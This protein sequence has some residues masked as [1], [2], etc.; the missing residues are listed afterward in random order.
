MVM[1]SVR[2]D[3]PLDLGRLAGAMAEV[4]AVMRTPMD[5]DQTL[6]MIT[7]SAADTVP[8]VIEASISVT[9][10][11]GRIDTLAPT[12][13]L[14]VQGDQLQ[15]D[16]HEGP[17]LDA[18]LGEPVVTVGDL[19]TDPRWPAFGPKAA[20]LGLGGHLAFQ[21][22]A[23][24]H[25]RGALNLYSIEPYGIDEDSVHLGSLFAGQL[26]LAMGWAKQDE[27]MSDALATRNVIGQAVGL[28]M[29]RYTLD[30]DRAFAFL[31]RLSQTSNIKL[32]QV[33]GALVDAAN[34]NSRRQYDDLHQGAGKA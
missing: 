4:A 18:A 22:R 15:Y 7:Q 29:E 10:K 11:D 20:A 34:S 1:E 31:T 13:P 14:A 19:A 17:C 5:L 25:V 23:D 26:A 16:L 3:A 21:F 8:G 9:R 28:V 12:G 30:A 33:A 24:P 27:T 32:R 6:R 2:A